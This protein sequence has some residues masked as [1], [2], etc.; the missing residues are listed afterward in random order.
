M[1]DL[2]DDW[3]VGRKE[4]LKVESLVGWMVDWMADHLVVE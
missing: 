2:M 4:I 3:K 1:V